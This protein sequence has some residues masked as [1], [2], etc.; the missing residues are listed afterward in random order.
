MI[1]NMLGPYRRNDGSWRVV[2]FEDDDRSDRRFPD[3][4]AAKE[5][6]RGHQLALPWRR[7]SLPRGEGRQDRRVTLA[8]VRHLLERRAHVGVSIAPWRALDLR[9]SG[10]CHYCGNEDLGAGLGLDRLDNARG[11]DEGNLVPCCARCNEARGHLLDPDEFAAAMQV[12]LAKT[13]PG[14]AWEGRQR[15]VDRAE[16]ADPRDR[17]WARRG[18]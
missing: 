18:A 10:P 1:R 4:Q 3:Q 8:L 5:F 7:K 15:A 16:P 2:V 9:N 13:G 6:M 14:R 17:A 12:R 11:Y